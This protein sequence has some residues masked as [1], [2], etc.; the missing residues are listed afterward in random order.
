MRRI[1]RGRESAAA[2]SAGA[3]NSSSSQKISPQLRMTPTAIWAADWTVLL[4][5]LIRECVAKYAR[6]GAYVRSHRDVSIS[7]YPKCIQ[8][9]SERS[10]LSARTM[11]FGAMSAE[12]IVGERMTSYEMHIEY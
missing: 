7:M 1:E 4:E 9:N 11:S 12:P 2:H 5:I 10:A 8:S 6:S 3:S